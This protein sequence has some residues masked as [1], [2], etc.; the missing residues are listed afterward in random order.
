MKTLLSDQSRTNKSE[1][2]SETKPNVI[3]IS[4]SV[5]DH[6]NNN[7]DNNPLTINT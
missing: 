6:K 7:S 3:N 4:Q 5:G 2:E 1:I